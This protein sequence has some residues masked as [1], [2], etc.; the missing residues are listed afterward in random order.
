MPHPHQKSRHP[1]PLVTKKGAGPARPTEEAIGSGP[2]GDARI[3]F[4]PR[5]VSN[6]NLG[7]RVPCGKSLFGDWL[8]R[9]DELRRLVALEKIEKNAVSPRVF[10]PET[11]ARRERALRILARTRQQICVNVEPGEA[12][13]GHSGLSGA[14][15]VAFAPEFQ[16]L[17]GDAEAVLGRAHDFKPRHARFAQRT[18]VEK[19]A[20]RAAGSAA[21][22]AA[23]LVK[24]GEAE[25]L[26]MFDDHD[27]RLGDVDAHFDDGRR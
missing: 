23:E 1:Q 22:A 26:G 16:V 6:E 27:R 10:A 13:A 21:D 11:F 4:A 15:H 20:R 9:L 3:G 24:L 25:T 17:L 8:S 14:E 18:P 19:E 2:F 7:P 5:I 12:K